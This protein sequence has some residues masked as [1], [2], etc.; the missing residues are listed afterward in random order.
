[1]ASPCVISFS[2]SLSS[3]SSSSSPIG[4]YTLQ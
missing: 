1:M 3:V 4:L 2:S